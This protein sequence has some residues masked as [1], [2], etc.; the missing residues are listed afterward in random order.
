MRINPFKQIYDKCNQGGPKFKLENLIDF[1]RYIDIELTNSCNFHCLMCS[2]GTNAT[3]RE[4]GFMKDE[5]Y[6][7]ILNEINEYKTPIRF[8]R[9]GEALLHPKLIGYIKDA[10]NMGIMCHLN[11]NASL[12]DEDK[13]EELIEIRL[14][15]IKFS[16]QGVDRKTYN[17]MRNVDFFDDLIVI[18]RHFYE[19]RGGRPYPYIHV[20][21]TITYETQEEVEE[22]KNFLKD[23]TDLVTVGRTVL[24]HLDTDKVRLGDKDKKIL[25]SLRE[26]ESVVEKRLKCCPEVF[27]KLSIN[28]DGKVTACCRDYDNKMIVGDLNKITLK[29]AWNSE[30]ISSYRRLLAERKYN[31]I[32]QCKDCYDHMQVQTPGTQNV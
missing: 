9:W 24:E 3:V 13:I 8:V 7:K 21:T 31:L 14:D 25:K 29:K 30:I 11:T 10:K 2:V 12:L 23:F 20:A 16:F 32:E 6:Y 1:P 19:K 27:D 17:E 4:K 28:W 22:F 5:I 26:L 15:S 18:V